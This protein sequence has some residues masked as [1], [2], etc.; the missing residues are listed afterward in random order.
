MQLMGSGSVPL[1]LHAGLLRDTGEGCSLAK[2]ALVGAAL[3]TPCAISKCHGKARL[4][5]GTRSLFL[6][7]ALKSAWGPVEDLILRA[8]FY[9]C[10]H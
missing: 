7:P 1:N 8:L 4:K 2:Q 5:E 3:P 10:A 9:Q 6:S